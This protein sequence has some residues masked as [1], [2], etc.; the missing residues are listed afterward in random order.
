VVEAQQLGPM[1]TQCGRKQNKLLFHR[2]FRQPVK[3]QV[4]TGPLRSA[5][6]IASLFPAGTSL[7]AAQRPLSVRRLLLQIIR[8]ESPTQP[9]WRIVGDHDLPLVKQSKA[10]C[11]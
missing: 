5:D 9:D 7:L 2:S 3:I 11:L 6:R 10:S 1:K 8:I 4:E